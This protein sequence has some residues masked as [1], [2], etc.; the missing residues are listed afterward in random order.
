MLNN[1]RA[2][3]ILATL[4]IATL[5]S[6][7]FMFFVY[8]VQK[9]LYKEEIDKK[10]KLGA[11]AGNL[12]L[13]DELV[14]KYDQS[15]PMNEEE[16]LQ[17]VKKLSQYAQSNGLEYIYLMVK[18]GD[19]VYTVISSATPDEL[20]NKE[21]DPF[22][23]EYEASEGIQNGFQD[24]HTFYEDTVDKYGSFRSYLQ[25]NRSAKGKLYMIG[26]DISVS[27]IENGLNELLIETVMIFAI[28]L[29]TAGAIA[30]WVSSLITRRLSLLTLNVEN[31]SN[32]LDLTTDFELNGNDE[33]AR[34]SNSL[35]HFLH[36]IRS[37]IYEAANVSKENVAL[38]GDTV[39]E[40]YGVTEKIKNTRELIHQS[41]E[42]IYEIS[43]Q[44]DEVSHYSG[45]VVGSISKADQQLESTKLS[46]HQVADSARQSARN[47][48]TLAQQLRQLKSEAE[49]I[50]SILTIIGD[51][52]NQTNLLAL[53][54]AIEAARAGEHGRGFAV[55]ADEVRKLAENT[56]SSLTDIASMTEVIIRSVGEI[57]D[58]TVESSEEISELAKITEASEESINNAAQSMREVVLTMNQTQER[59]AAL[60]RHG[61]STSKRMDSID[62][63]SLANIEIIEQMDKKISRL[64]ALSYELGEKLNFCRMKKSA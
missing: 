38:A 41:L 42:E 33:I 30:M 62:H 15:T 61:E 34:L 39:N 44:I 2:K 17:L 54:A 28:V 37:V 18:E 16:H 27:S 11:Q 26:A 25:I 46:I 40:A 51:I 1:L 12:Y 13:G 8:D 53:N 32:S 10:L 60:H 22:Y 58:G 57:A 35:N 64:S 31:L 9:N 55:V 7:L 19:K 5:S 21:Y 20:K 50:R 45:S 6:L 49:Q 14:D 23:T 48:E 63:D 56:Q 29:M 43:S 36:T 52:A 3:I 4:S 47:G 24:G 59:L